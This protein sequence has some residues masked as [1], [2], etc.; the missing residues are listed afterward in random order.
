M[1]RCREALAPRC[2]K[3]RSPDRVFFKQKKRKLN[4]IVEI[5]NQKSEI[6]N[7]LWSNLTRFRKW[8]S[9]YECLLAAGLFAYFPTIKYYFFEPKSGM[10]G[11]N[12][13]RHPAVPIGQLSR[14]TDGV[15]PWRR[16]AV[17]IAEVSLQ[18]FPSVSLGLVVTIH[19][20]TLSG[21][22]GSNLWREPIRNAV[23]L[24]TVFNWFLQQLQEKLRI[25]YCR[26]QEYFYDLKPM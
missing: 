9:V 14:L 10:H 2:L 4:Q 3:T 16:Q 20:G 13:Q 19:Y 7:Q 12:L 23:P 1:P 22:V 17:G 15:D 21:T 8:C 18:L 26:L 6:T 5:F 11:G 25:V 24:N